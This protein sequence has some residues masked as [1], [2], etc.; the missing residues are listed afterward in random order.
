[1][2][3][4]A[5]RASGDTITTR[6]S[7]RSRGVV[8]VV[9]PLGTCSC[10]VPGGVGAAPDGGGGG[11]EPDGRGVSTRVSVDVRLCVCLRRRRGDCVPDT[12]S[13]VSDALL[14]SLCSSAARDLLASVDSSSDVDDSV[15]LRSSSDTTAAAPSPLPPRAVLRRCSAGE[16]FDVASRYALRVSRRP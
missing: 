12:A 10:G 11:A 8:V 4:A 6:S 5:S 1:V 15:S 7:A 9:T 14:T 16:S 13:L 3:T 2:R